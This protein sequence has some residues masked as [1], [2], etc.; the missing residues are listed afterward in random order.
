VVKIELC[1]LKNNG[2]DMYVLLDERMRIVEP[3]YDFLKYHKNKDKAPNTLEANGRDLKQFWEFLNKMGYLYDMVTPEMISGFIEYLRDPFENDM[4]ISLNAPSKRVAKTIN[5]ILS[6]VHSFY[7]YCLMVKEIK[8]PILM[9]EVNRPFDMFKNLLEHAKKDNK[10][11]K[12]LFKVKEEDVSWRLVADEDIERFINA[13]PSRR[14]KLLFKTLRHTGARIQEV[15]D[16]QITDVPYPDSSN[17]I[18][19]LKDIKSKGKRRDLYMP[20]FLLEEIDTFIMEERSQIETDHDYIFVS[21]KKQYLGKPLTYS[22]IYDTLLTV[23]DKTAIKFNFHDLR[24]TFITKLVESGMDISVVQKIAGHE[25]ISTTQK[26]THLS[27]KF[28][29]EGLGKYWSKSIFIGGAASGQ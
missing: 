26:Y 19:V 5:R 3:V 2:K 15:L 4:V 28:I 25:H 22:A 14:D 1:I 6:T 21:N 16:L 9:E 10:T 13:V 11:G 23:R 12:S 18:G 20:M 24:H 27:D 7:K 8:N 17:P 29:E